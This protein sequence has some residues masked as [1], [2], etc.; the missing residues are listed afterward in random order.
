MILCCEH[1]AVS[2]Q[3]YVNNLKEATQGR[4]YIP[5]FVFNMDDPNR[6]KE[7]RW[8]WQRLGSHCGSMS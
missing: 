5:V 7:V 4:L 6:S 8:A 3:I 2:L 1:F